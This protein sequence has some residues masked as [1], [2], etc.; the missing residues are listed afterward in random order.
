MALIYA[1]ASA[2]LVLDPEL[3]TFSYGS[4]GVEQALALVL[5]SSWMSRCWTL[6]EASLSKAWYIQFKDVPIDLANA[7]WH[8]GI[9]KTL[10]FLIGQ[11]ELFPSIKRALV[12]ELSGFLVD[13]GEVRYQRRGRYSRSEIWNLRQL[14]SHQAL[15]FATAWNNFQGRTTSKLK[16]LHQILAGM[17]DVKAGALQAFSLEDRMKADQ[18]PCVAAYIS[19]VLCK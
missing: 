7:A 19:T 17:A 14:E 12:A 18:V 11:G 1:G 3:Q 5:R 9:K 6:Q 15:S 10:D 2:I 4:V 8:L 16:D 13:M